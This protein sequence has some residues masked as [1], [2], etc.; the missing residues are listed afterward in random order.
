MVVRDYGVDFVVMIAATVLLVSGLVKVVVP[1]PIAAT[2]LALW[3]RATGRGAKT[4]SRLLGRAL[5]SAEIGL[6]AWIVLGRSTPAGVVLCVFAAGLAAAGLMGVLGAGDVPCACFG[7]HD[8][9]LGYLHVLQL[10]LWVAAAWCVSRRTELAAGFDGR[11]AMFGACAAAA[12]GFHVARMWIVLAPTARRR[13]RAAA[14]RARVPTSPHQ[15][16]LGGSSW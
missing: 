14:E 15:P 13:R 3:S 8:R 9:A 10:P 4:G 7:G 16:Q 5:G 12:S 11:V 1:G 2:M 6:S